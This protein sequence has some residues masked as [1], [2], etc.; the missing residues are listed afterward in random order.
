VNVLD[1]HLLL[2]LA[3]VAVERFEQRTNLGAALSSLFR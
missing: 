2:A 3:A 1:R